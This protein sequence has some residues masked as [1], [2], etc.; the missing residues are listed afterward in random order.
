MRVDCMQDAAASDDVAF[1]VMQSFTGNFR[2]LQEGTL[3]E[4]DTKTRVANLLIDEEPTMIDEFMQL[5]ESCCRTR[6]WSGLP[7]SPP[8]TGSTSTE[9]VH[10][11]E[12]EGG[13]ARTPLYHS[14][15]GIGTISSAPAHEVGTVAGLSL[16][17]I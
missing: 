3:S 8:G 4:S 13:I 14:H 16:I 10:L 2:A 6:A 15:S 9:D 11:S 17:H 7:P 5:F 12:L 1:F